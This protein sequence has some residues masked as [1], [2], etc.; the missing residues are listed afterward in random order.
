MMSNSAG[1]LV[2]CH[3][4]GGGTET[5]VICFDFSMDELTWCGERS[6]VIIVVIRLPQKYNIITIIYN[7]ILI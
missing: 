2:M 1:F 4:I 7:I 5:K 6:V 3:S